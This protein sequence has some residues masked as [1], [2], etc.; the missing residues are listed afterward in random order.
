MVELTYGE[1]Q[2]IHGSKWIDGGACPAVIVPVCQH[3]PSGCS[4][5]SKGG[6]NLNNCFTS[7]TGQGSRLDHAQQLKYAAARHTFASLAN[8]VRVHLH[9]GAAWRGVDVRLPAALH[10]RR[11]HRRRVRRH[12]VVA[13]DMLRARVRVHDG[14]RRTDGRRRV[15]IL[16]RRMLPR[17]RAVGVAVVAA[18][19]MAVGVG[20]RLVGG[21]RRLGG[22]DGEM[23][24]CEGRLS[25]VVANWRSARHQS[26]GA[27]LDA[28][29]Q[30][31]HSER[32]ACGD[33]K[34][35]G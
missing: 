18:A 16:R 30:Q 22:V 5:H 17:R 34:G 14:V 13:A 27:T 23:A 8:A 26:L 33:G 19:G 1:G 7:F 35:G 6:Y 12:P 15:H 25:R 21:A 9:A 11:V 20:M 31:Q 10:L 3:E 28:V 29:L 2:E 32:E 4:R 24:V